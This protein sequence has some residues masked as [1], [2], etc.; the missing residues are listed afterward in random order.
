MIITMQNLERLSLAEMREFIDGSRTV[1]FAAQGREKIYGFLERIL[2]TQQYRR[3]TRGRR[4][5][6]RRFLAKVT[7][8]SRA[9]VTRLIGRWLKSRRIEIRPRHRPSFPRRYTAADVVLLAAVDA[10]HEDLSGPAVRRILEREYR[11]FSKPE[12]ERLAGISVSHIYNLRAS[13]GYRR[14]R[15]RVARLARGPASQPQPAARP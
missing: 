4:G 8:L 14:R 2:N 6:V 5:I 9:Q 13:E 3:L 10:A 7:G 11:V 1:A 12:Y 15:V